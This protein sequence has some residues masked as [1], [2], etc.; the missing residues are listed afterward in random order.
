[1]KKKLKLLLKI[2]FTVGALWFVL[3]KVDIE[4]LK[5][6]LSGAEPLWLFGAFI[7]FNLSKIAGALRLN[8]Y[9][10]AIGLKLTES[11]NLVL[12]YVGMFYN[13]FLPGGIGGDG[14]KVY[15]LNKHYKSGVKPLLQA[16]LLDRL[17][18]LAALVLYACLLFA[19]SSYAE[20]YPFAMP[21]ALFFALLVFPVSYLATKLFFR[22]YLPVFKTTMLWGLGVQFLQLLCAWMIVESLGAGG[23]LVEYL[24]LFLISS[25]VAV[26]PLT[27]GGV[28]IRELTFLYGLGW[29]GLEPSTGVTFSFLFFIITAISS[30]FGLFLLERVTPE[31]PRST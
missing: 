15:L 10:R 5:E 21:L 19:A 25:V 7:L 2:L 20:I 22:T 23:H 16:V 29:L 26:L 27:I 18:G 11:Y 3:H 30:L 14:Y 24:T 4:K 31:T 28:G 9:F 12:Y 8:I 6:A 17:S 1:M 13:L